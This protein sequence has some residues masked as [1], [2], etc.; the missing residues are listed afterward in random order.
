L[1]EKNNESIPNVSRGISSSSIARKGLL[2][3]KGILAALASIR[4]TSET[5]R[6]S[7][8][9]LLRSLEDKKKKMKEKNKLGKRSR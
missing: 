9:V 7:Y 6:I 5:S 1:S 8:R 2:E 3:P 4:V